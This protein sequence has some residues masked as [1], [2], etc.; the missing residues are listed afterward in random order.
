MVHVRQKGEGEHPKLDMTPMIDVVFQLLIFF[1]VTLKQDDI[2]ARLSASR[3]MSVSVD[4][5]IELINL[6]VSSQGLA[7]NGQTLKLSDL[8][9]Q[10]GRIAA[11]S[12][13]ASVVVKCRA[14]SP[15]AFLIQVLDICQKYGLSNVSVCSL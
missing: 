3:P 9:R 8:D 4:H 6:V 7:L 10:L 5:P 2:F 1:V 14:D 11:F 15:H 13:S 12:K